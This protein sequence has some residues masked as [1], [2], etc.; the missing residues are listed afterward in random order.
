MATTGRL[1]RVKWDENLHPR[2]GVG[3]FISSGDG[4]FVPPYRRNKMWD[5]DNDRW[6]GNTLAGYGENLESDGGMAPA[7]Q[8]AINNY[9]ESSGWLNNGLRRGEIT[10]PA[11]RE[12]VAHLDSAIERNRI[13]DEGAMVYRGVAVGDDWADLEEGDQVVDRGYLSTSMDPLVAQGFG[14]DVLE[15]E[16]PPGTPVAVANAQEHEYLVGRGSVIEVL[17]FAPGESSTARGTNRIIRAR[18]VG[19]VED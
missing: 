10:D 14:T 5:P 7:E 3:R 16:L 4:G 17:G 8:A 9:T 13:D 2:S 1:R 12:V 18:L 6:R 11:D 15:L 19:Y